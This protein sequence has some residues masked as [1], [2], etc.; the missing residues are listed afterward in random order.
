[1][2]SGKAA[3]STKP[4]ALGSLLQAATYGQ[5][6]PVIY[7]MTQSPLLAIW[8]ANIRQGG[9]TKKLK[10]D[11]KG[12][13]SYVENIDFLLGHNPIMGVQQCWNNG[14]P[15]PLNFVN[16]ALGGSGQPSY[17]I[18]DPYFYALIA[19]TV[20]TTYTDV[21][22]N[23]YGGSGPQ[24]LT[25]TM[26]TPCWNTLFSGPAWISQQSNFP[27]T[28]R[29]EPSYGP[30][31]YLDGQF[32]A[33]QSGVVTAYYS[34]LRAATSY[35]PPI[36]KEM[37]FFEP[38]LGDGDEYAEANLTAQ[39]II[40]PMFAGLGSSAIDLGIAGVIPQLQVEV[41][42]KWGLYSTG[43][44]DFA[45]MIEDI[46]RS[47]V[48][49]AAIGDTS[50]TSPGF[51]A[52]EHGLSGYSYPACVQNQ[53]LGAVDGPF[54]PIPYNQPN[55]LGNFLVVIATS[56]FGTTLG[57]S[58]TAGN[59]WTAV[60]ASGIGVQVWWAQVKANGPNTVTITG[61]TNDSGTQL[62]EIGGVDTFDSATVGTSPSVSQ[63]TTNQQNFPAYIMAVS[64]WFDTG[65]FNTTPNIPLWT[66]LSA[67]NN[68]YGIS[69]PYELTFSR[70]VKTPGTYT[71]TMPQPT[72]N[73]TSIC[74]LA[75]KCAI[76]PPTN[77]APVGDF[78][79]NYSLDLVRQQCRANGLWGSLTMDSQQAASD[80]LTTL[81]QAA[82]AAP[83]FMGFK[84]YSVP[85]S[86]VSAVGNGAIYN[87]PTAC[88]PVA[89]LSTE[90][91]DFLASGNTA[92]LTIKTA[93]RVDQPNVLQM[94]VI[95]RTSN[96]N[97]SVVEQPDAVGISLFGVRKADPVVN[98]AIQDVSIARQILG[99]MVRKLQY[100]GDLYSFTL[101]AKW[102]LLSP[103]TLIT[104]TD[105]LADINQVPVRITSMVEQSD[106][107]L[108][109]EAEPFIYGMYAPTPF[110]TSQSGG[111]APSTG[112]T[113]EPVNIPIIFE[114]VPGLIGAT[115]QGQVWLVISDS[116]PNYG[117]AQV[118]VSTDGGASYQ[119]AGPPTTG[120]GIQGV[121]VGDW[122]AGSS[123]DTTSDLSVNLTESAE[124]LESYPV[125]TEDGFVNPC[126]VASGPA[127][128]TLRGS[129]LA[130]TTGT[131]GVNLTLPA[132]SQVGD[133]A[134]LFGSGGYGLC[135]PPGATGPF[136]CAPTTWTV[137]LQLATTGDWSLLVC[138]KILTSDDLTEGVVTVEVANLVA[139]DVAAGIVV[140]EGPTGGIR[141]IE[142]NNTAGANITITNTTSGAVLNTDVA[143]YWASARSDSPPG[144]PTLAVLTPSAGVS[145]TLQ[146]GITTDAASILADQAMSGGAV[147]VGNFF[148][149]AGNGAVAVQI[150]VEAG[151]TPAVPYELMTYGVATLTSV[152]NYTLQATGAGN[153]L[154][155]AVFG[156]P[157]PT[158]GTD[159][160]NGSAFALL[161]P[162]GQGICK[163]P[164]LPAWIGETVYFKLLPFNSFGVVSGT[165]SDATAYPYTILGTSGAGVNTLTVNGS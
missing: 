162:S 90:N 12:I 155:R 125:A 121:T 101:P 80:W 103:M 135:P 18:A 40:Y 46:F 111:S 62:F 119:I 60:L 98:N 8:T 102:C 38:Q 50:G 141:E 89:N 13:T 27:Y 109:C 17:T 83:L 1:M 37:L 47:G 128:P 69:P 115:N 99:I 79:D 151:G 15:I 78:I 142:G 21:E 72:F 74:S 33:G 81:Y 31:F 22:F 122:P 42:G 106:G 11:L 146:T 112:G 148:A 150:I 67:P 9:G 64:L 3:A 94:Q 49:Q 153:H 118:Y 19:V 156:A 30:T 39:Q 87:A 147:S 161:P 41:Q 108:Q 92:P 43:D 63:V 134:V 53:F 140:F 29:W 71:F 159:H 95:N 5:T 51:T 104:V 138:S 10:Q 120:N 124:T 116:D 2:I 130:T 55:T 76:A 36:Q 77:P 6:I 84:L 65:T 59:T 7:G 70:I 82:D 54:L 165:L 14:S 154:D 57:I 16:V 137:Q 129:A 88:G 85:Y 24:S 45:D 160:P 48:A 110:S 73:P 56:G 133:L 23:D 126:Y 163:L 20:D 139:F 105:P 68:A 25:G 66:P 143:I 86:E 34:Q 28:Y 4:T 145:N 32:Y 152:F 75:F 107:S 97:P 144:D 131:E 114:P 113:I 127:T 164:L 93:A 58:D 61:Q 136:M 157:T 44:A 100:G 35:L 123:P 91:G 158:E 26:P 117:G 52:V 132:G 149:S 96:Y